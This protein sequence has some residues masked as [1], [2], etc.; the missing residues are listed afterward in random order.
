MGK[1]TQR[2][3]NP[4]NDSVILHLPIYD[5]ISAGMIVILWAGD[6]STQQRDIEKSQQYWIDYRCRNHA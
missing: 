4:E 3:G 2:F 6:K 1:E 5:R